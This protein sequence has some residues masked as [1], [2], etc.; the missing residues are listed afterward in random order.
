MS[1]NRF[2]TVDEW[3]TLGG[4]APT[5]ESGGGWFSREFENYNFPEQ[6]SALVMPGDDSDEEVDHPLAYRGPPDHPAP[7]HAPGHPPGG[8]PQQGGGPRNDIHAEMDALLNGNQTQLSP[9]QQMT[10]RQMELRNR[11]QMAAARAPQAMPSIDR[12]MQREAPGGVPI[13]GPPP[14][15][16]EEPDNFFGIRCFRA[17]S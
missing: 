16:T 6:D 14:Q 11:A 5:S 9:E 8:P 13:G 4:Q 3:R 12:V 17:C 7:H 10:L 1:F 15:R 2:E